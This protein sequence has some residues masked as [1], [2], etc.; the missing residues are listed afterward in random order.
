MLVPAPI[1]NRRD[2]RGDL[3]LTLAEFGLFDLNEISDVSAFRGF[4][5]HAS[6]AN[7]PTEDSP[8]SEN[9]R[10]SRKGGCV[11]YPPLISRAET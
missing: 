4:G 1:L 2:R 11:R 3:L 5:I 10:Q 8:R 9:P 6:R 7:G